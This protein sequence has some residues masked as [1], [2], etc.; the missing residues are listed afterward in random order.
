[1]VLTDLVGE[2]IKWSLRWPRPPQALIDE[3]SPGFVST[4]A[5][6]SLAVA[7]ILAR[8]GGGKWRL[9]LIPWVLGVAWSRLRLGVHFPLDILGGWAVGALLA[10]L[11]ERWGGDKRSACYLSLGLGLF[12][13][14]FWPEGGGESLQRDLGLLLGLE[15][16]LLWRLAGRSEAPAPP[17]LSGPLVLLRLLGLLGLYFGLK[18]GGVP[19]W[20]RYLALG[21]WSSWRAQSDSATKKK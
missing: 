2:A 15:F 1:M 5:A 14:A 21:L 18:I 4:H 11:V 12:W 17:P 16:G 8:A 7:L 13:V 6:L 3:P 10:G 20:L 9:W 19:R